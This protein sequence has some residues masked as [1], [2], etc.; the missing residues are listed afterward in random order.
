MGKSF[1]S[2]VYQCQHP[3][4]DILVSFCKLLEEAGKMMH[5]T[6]THTHTHMH[7][8][9]LQLC[10]ILC[11]PM[12][13][14]LPSSSAHGIL[15]VRIMECVVIPSSRHLPNPGIKPTSFMSPALSGG[16]FTISATW[17]VYIHIISYN[18]MKIY[19]SFKIKFKQLYIFH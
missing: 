8:K 10:L 15:Q 16:F 2:S 3:A 18:S 19:K 11:N 17:K 4:C 14:S 5:G 6:H 9:S 13:C 1:V 12:D 7:A